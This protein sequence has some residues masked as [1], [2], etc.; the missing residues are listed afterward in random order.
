MQ[1]NNELTEKEN[2]IKAI[3]SS[4]TFTETA[5]KC[6]F[7]KRTLFNRIKEYGIKEGFNRGRRGGSR[8]LAKPQL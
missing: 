5:E 4:Q 6:G 7:S 1:K 2:I 3:N 8:K